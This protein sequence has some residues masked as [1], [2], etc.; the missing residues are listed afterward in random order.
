M[1]F[2]RGAEIQSAGG[3]PLQHVL[4]TGEVYETVTRQDLRD[5]GVFNAAGEAVPFALERRPEPTPGDTPSLSL[6]FFPVYADPA[7]P[8]DDVVVRVERTAAGQIMRV[9]NRRAPGRAAAVR[10]LIIDASTLETP[11][12]SLTLQWADTT[13]AFIATLY[14]ETSDDLNRWRPWGQATLA[15][16]TF[17]GNVLR[18]SE[19][20]LPPKAAGYIRLSWKGTADAAALPPVVAAIFGEP[21]MTLAEPERAWM[22]LAPVD[23]PLPAEGEAS[24]VYYRQAGVAP[25]DRLRLDLPQSNTVARVTVEAASTPEGPWRVQYTGLV[26]RLERAGQ[27]IQ[28]PDLRVQA[29]PHAYWRI[30]SEAAG[31][32][33]ERTP[34]RLELG[35]VPDRLLFVR[36]GEAPFLLA[37][38][39]ATAV[40]SRFEAGELRGLVAEGP[41]E[42]YTEPIATLGPVRELGGSNRLVPSQEIPWQRVLL[43]A[44]LLAGVGLLATMLL[45]LLKQVDRSPD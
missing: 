25:I 43:W 33:F 40:S 5:A 9:E 1:D 31:S 42:A 22:T 45:R 35:W 10:A 24:T 44:A 41:G 28:T 7:L 4:L 21:V 17:G 12:R 39:S 2:A 32:G 13:Q 26:Y 14:A 18:Q 16:L 38:G 19:L 37:F 29:S 23:P 34:P 15:H 8:L 3:G 27:E 30:R 36:R 20:R 6:P 11:L